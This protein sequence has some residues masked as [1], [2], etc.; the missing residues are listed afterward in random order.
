MALDP[1]APLRVLF[2]SYGTEEEGLFDAMAVLRLVAGDEQG[3]PSR[4]CLREGLLRRWRTV[5]ARAVAQAVAD[6]PDGALRIER[7]AYVS[8]DQKDH[9]FD[10]ADV[11]L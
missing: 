10:N 5:L 4:P 11:F 9:C 1:D 6:C 7:L 8:G 3:R 2:L